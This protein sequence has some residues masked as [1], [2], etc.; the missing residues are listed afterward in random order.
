VIWLPPRAKVIEISGKRVEGG[1]GKVRRVQILRMENIP[2]N[3][4]F[5]GKQQKAKDEFEK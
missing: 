1:Y 4:D 2:R 5:V 3:I